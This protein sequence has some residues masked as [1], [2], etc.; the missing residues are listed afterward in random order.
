MKYQAE[1][2]M[3]GSLAIGKNLAEITEGEREELKG[4]IEK[5]KSIRHIVHLGDIYRLASAYDKPYAAFEYL[6]G[7]EGVLFM[8]GTSQQFM[9]RPEPLRLMGLDEDSLYRIEDGG[10]VSFNPNAPGERNTSPEYITMSGKALM[11][12]GLK[13]KLEGDFDS[14]VIRFKKV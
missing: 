13:I 12:L 14:R 3:M 2:A 10:V 8:L 11:K 1:A 7:G 6:Y 5:Y 4:Y 9:V